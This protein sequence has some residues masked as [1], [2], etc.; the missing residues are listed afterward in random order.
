MNTLDGCPILASFA[1][2]GIFLDG[3]SPSADGAPYLPVFG[4]CGKWWPTFAA[5]ANVG[6]EKVLHLPEVISLAGCGK[7]LF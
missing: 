4:R 1:G 5:L 3:A 2:V 7:T 6:F